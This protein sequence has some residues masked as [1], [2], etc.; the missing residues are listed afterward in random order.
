MEIDTLRG[1]SVSPSMNS[2]REVLTHSNTSSTSYHEKMEIQNHNTTWSKQVD[3]EER[4]KLTL[5]YATP[6]A[7]KSMTANKIIN[8]S[9]KKGAQQTNNKVPALNNSTCP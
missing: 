1:R 7:E 3:K 9:P 2:S 6:R 4:K 8:D 5:L